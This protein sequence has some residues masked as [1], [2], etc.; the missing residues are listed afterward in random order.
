MSL[1]AKP[2]LSLVSFD[3]Q[4]YPLGPFTD[5]QTENQNS[6]EAAESACGPGLGLHGPSFWKLSREADGIGTTAVRIINM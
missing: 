4:N 3:P 6:S 1:L 5:E 2:S